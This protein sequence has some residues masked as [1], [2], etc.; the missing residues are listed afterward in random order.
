MLF[1]GD[2]GRYG[3]PVLPD[4]TPV[5]EA[6]VLLLESTYGDRLH[7]PDDDGA[8][9]AAIVNDTARARRQADHPV[10]CDRP[11][12]GSAVLAEAARGGK[13]DPRAAG[14]RRQPDGDRRVAVLFSPPQRARRRSCNLELALRTPVSETRS[15]RL[16]G[17]GAC[18]AFATTRMTT[19]A[20][21]QQSADLVASRQPSIVIASSGMAT[22]GRVLH[23]LAA[24]IS[25]PKNTVLFV[26]YQAAGT[27]GRLLVD[28]A[29]EIKLLGRDLPGRRARRADRLDVGARRRQRDHALAVRLHARAE[30]DLSRPR[31][32]GRARRAR[33]RA[34]PPRS[35]GRCTSPRISSASTRM[36]SDGGLRLDEASDS[37]MRIE[38][39]RRCDRR[40][41][42]R[43]PLRAADRQY[44]LE[45]V[46]EAAVVQ[47]YA[48]GFRDLPLREKMLIWH[49]YQAAIAGRDI[50]YDQR[51]AHNL[52]MRDVARSDRHAPGRRRS[53]TLDEIDALH[54]A[55]LDQHRPLQQPDRA[56]VRARVHARR[57]S[58]PRRTPPQRA[59]ARFPLRAGE[60]LDA[61]LARLQPM[62]FDPD[63]DPTVTSKTPRAGKDI[64]TASANN[65]YVGVTM[66]DLDGFEE[67][68]PLNSRLVK[69]DGRLVEE[70]YRVGGRYGAQIAAI[71]AAPRGGD[72]V[73]DRADGDGAA[74]ADHV[75]PDRRGRRPRGLRHRLGA[76]QG[77]AGRHH[78]RLHRGLSRRA[79]HQGRV[80]SARLLRQPARRRRRSRRSPRTRSG[81]KTACRGIRSTARKASTASPPTPS[82]S[83]SRP[84]T[85]GRSRRSASTCRTI[86]RSASATAASRCRCRTSTRRTTGRRCP[87]SAASSRG[88][89]KRPRARSG[90]ARSPAS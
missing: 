90:G 61:L 58:P 26:G 34:S 13:T 52:E 39:D 79:R 45:R 46:G 24:T 71:V 1:G 30:H 16:R 38:T 50:Y 7:E 49:L 12:R 5:A 4:P 33:R 89:R 22:G 9:L 53:T 29:T 85:R 19:V 67:Q 23:H 21:P 32:A 54:Q 70:V 64:L 27:R 60:T 35:S 86:R 40:R 77:V 11:R 17:C 73:R 43:R 72:S 51:Y 41:R 87:S 76:G 80:G 74:R 37:R 8:R 84:A 25:N 15:E 66:E 31:R 62:F 56:Q 88:R 83:S 18:R 78:Q 57:P 48:D 47:V 55:V 81:S 6:D 75:L 20:S 3:R 28:G 10:V 63:V 69:R 65:L 2:L 44:L 59:G 82:T 68:H 36:A 42:R 14:L